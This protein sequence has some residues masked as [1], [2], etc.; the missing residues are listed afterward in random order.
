VV[1]RSR[2]GEHTLC[3]PNISIALTLRARDPFVLRLAPSGRRVYA[4]NLV[5]PPK[6]DVLAWEAAGGTQ[7]EAV[8]PARG[9]ELW[10]RK[11][12][13]SAVTV[14]HAGVESAS[15]IVSQKVLEGVQPPLKSTTGEIAGVVQMVME[16]PRVVSL[17]ASYGL[18]KNE[19]VVDVDSV[20]H[21]PGGPGVPSTPAMRQVAFV[22]WSVL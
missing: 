5:Q 2:T 4:V 8:A 21:F 7:A 1:S 10:L 9:A 3:F 13:S 15:K 12:H 11:L 16:D 19:Y 6:L 22:C 18:G 14:V 17:A 20:G